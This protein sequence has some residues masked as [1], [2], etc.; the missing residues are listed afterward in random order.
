MKLN[1]NLLKYYRKRSELS[2][3]DMS[4]KLGISLSLYQSFE[5][6]RRNP[7]YEIIKDI[8]DILKINKYAIFDSR[9]MQDVDIEVENKINL[10][11]EKQIKAKKLLSE[12]KQIVV[13]LEDFLCETESEN[14]D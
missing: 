1:N 8:A 14:I 4:N 2:Q 13:E 11:A 5:Q 10:L 7:S 12:L 9:I 6:G 3:K